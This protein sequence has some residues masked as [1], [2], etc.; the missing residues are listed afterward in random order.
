MT[1]RSALRPGL[2]LRLWLAAAV[3]AALAVAAAAVA[4]C[5]L[6]RT[7]AHAAEAMAAQRRIEAYGAFSA[8]VNGWML[9]WL[10]R[11]DGPP[12]AAPVLA[13]LDGLDR[14]VAED[15]AAAP[16]GAE[17]TQRA[18]QSVTPARL[19]ALFGQL[20]T[21]LKATPPGTPGGD[22]AVAF[23]AAQAPGVAAQQAEQEIR[24]RDTALAAMEGLQRPLLLA[25]VGVGVAAPLVLAALY[26]LVL[27]P[28]FA[29]LARVAASA[30]A[31]AMGSLPAGAG[32]HDELGLMLARLRQM[33]RRID[34]R[35][36]RLAHDHEQLEG[37]VAGRTAALSAAND[38]LA[39]VDATR[40]RFFADVGHELR[41]PLTVIMG[42]AELGLRRPD[43]ATRAGFDTILNRAA[44]L[45]R[46]IEDL[47]RI[48]RSDS[49]QLELQQDRVALDQ[50]VAAALADLAPVL[51]RAGVGV[52]TELAALAVRGDADWLRQVFAGLFENAAKYA[53]RGAVVSVTGRAEGG[54]ARV[55]IRD[56]G[57][58]LPPDLRGRVFERFARG[59]TAP[60]FGVGLALAAWVVEASGGRLDLLPEDGPGLGL[61]MDLPLWEEG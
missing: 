57:P 59:S 29:R 30:Q 40:R 25:A 10:T 60:G 12:D 20:E 11:Q 51:K 7:H 56:T 46:R 39:Q 34:R 49:G 41:T 24:R 21:A 22:A 23:Y 8:Q 4:V 53:G 45:Y 17:A 1:G 31:M 26:L 54:V 52:T 5:G 50:T 55:L 6:S 43:P 42:E 37:I 19:R 47:L 35:R 36:A 16:S 28:L 32:G 9:G 38:R 3:L 61:R 15:V 14:L 27:R 48:A 58:G 33:A 18:R 44:R 13:A 2:R